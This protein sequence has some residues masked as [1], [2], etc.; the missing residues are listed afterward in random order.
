ML[1]YFINRCIT[2][3]QIALFPNLKATLWGVTMG[4]LNLVA[5]ILHSSLERQ[6]KTIR[7]CAAGFKAAHTVIFCSTND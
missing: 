3:K 6:Q 5:L 7:A 2:Y 4:N 1:A